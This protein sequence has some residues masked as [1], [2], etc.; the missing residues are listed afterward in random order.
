MNDLSPAERA[1]AMALQARADAVARRIRNRLEMP[2]TAALVDA[3]TDVFGKL[4]A[5]RFTEN[6]RTVEWGRQLE[7]RAKTREAA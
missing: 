6:G 1:A 4:P 2:G 3:F 7:L 5:G